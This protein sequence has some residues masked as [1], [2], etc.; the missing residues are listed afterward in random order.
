MNFHQ[1]AVLIGGI[2]LLLC[3]FS[4]LWIVLLNKGTLSI[5][6]DV[7]F[8]VSAQGPALKI[9]EEITCGETPCPFMLP[10]GEYKLTFSKQN[11]FEETLSATVKRGDTTS[12]SVDFQFIPTV[13]SIGD[14]EAFKT[15][16]TK[17][18]PEAD[19]RFEMDSTYNKQKLVY[20]NPTTFLSTVW[21]YFDRPL[22]KPL[23]FPSPTLR[24]A[25]VVDQA[26]IQ[27]DLYL[28]DGQEFDHR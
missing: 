10:Q 1:K 15:F 6:G 26:E 2:T 16:F 4:F 7:P 14:Y 27:S 19:F 5:S 12:L 9:P 20:A 17:P 13:E 25:I 23:V 22:E 18:S 21:A 8:S 24:H 3:L 28:I 11:Y